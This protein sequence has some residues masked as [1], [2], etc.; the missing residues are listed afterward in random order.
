MSDRTEAYFPS[1]GTVISSLFPDE[2]ALGYPGVTATGVEPQA[3]ETA[4][5]FPSH[6]CVSVPSLSIG[7]LILTDVTE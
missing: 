6:T 4:P 2:T 1:G 5:A 3:A 7:P